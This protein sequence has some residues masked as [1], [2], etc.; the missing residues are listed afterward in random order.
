MVTNVDG[1][2]PVRI[3]MPRKI[4]LMEE[5]MRIKSVRGFK[6]LCCGVVW[7]FGEG[8]PAQVSFSSLNQG[9]KLQVKCKNMCSF[10]RSTLARQLRVNL[11][12]PKN[13]IPSCPVLGLTFP[14]FDINSFQIFFYAIEIQM[15]LG[16]LFR[17]PYDLATKIFFVT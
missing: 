5:L 7:K 2:S 11:G 10:L 9:S 1:E 15:S 17:V 14:V 6:F 13:S 16:L 8:K 3:L 12:L 4:H